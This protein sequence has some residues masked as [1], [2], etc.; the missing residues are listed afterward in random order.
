MARLRLG[1]EGRSTFFLGNGEVLLAER[2]PAETRKVNP[3]TFCHRSDHIFEKGTVVE[4]FAVLLE[5]VIFIL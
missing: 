2:V 5:D 4:W 3:Q 1:F